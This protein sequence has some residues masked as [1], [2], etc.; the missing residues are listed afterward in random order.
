MGKF[1]TELGSDW[2][3]VAEAI[4]IQDQFETFNTP[5]QFLPPGTSLVIPFPRGTRLQITNTAGDRMIQVQSTRFHYNWQKAKEKYPR[6]RN[7]REEFDAFFA[8]F[9]TF[10]AQ[11][12]IGKLIP[13]QWEIT[14]INFIPT[15]ELWRTA[16]EW[17]RVFPGL[18]GTFEGR[19]RVR[20]ETISGEWHYE[21]TP[22]LGRLH[23]GPALG[24][25]TTSNELGLVLNLTARGPLGSDLPLGL[26]RGLELGHEMIVQT[27]LDITSPDAQRAWGRKG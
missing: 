6:Y 13:N 11:A 3:R 8:R 12:G 16:S 25:V 21:I 15:E 19:D 27:F 9:Q 4:P 24:K 7:V 2:T 20:L 22:Q 26:G 17:S 23:I 18:L 10:V 1:W 5:A 14:Y